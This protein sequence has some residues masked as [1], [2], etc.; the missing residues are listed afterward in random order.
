[1]KYKEWLQLIKKHPH[2]DL[3]GKYV[4]YDIDGAPLG[5]IVYLKGRV[6]SRRTYKRT[7]SPQKQ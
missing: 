4:A 3:N 2:K 5:E 1:M 6:V 7:K